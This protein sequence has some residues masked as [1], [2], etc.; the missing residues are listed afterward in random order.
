MVTYLLSTTQGAG[1]PGGPKP[2][3]SQPT[4]YLPTRKRYAHIRYCRD[5]VTSYP[6]VPPIGKAR[7]DVIRGGPGIPVWGPAALDVG[8]KTP[9]TAGQCLASNEVLAPRPLPAVGSS[10][11]AA[12]ARGEAGRGGRRAAGG[13]RGAGSGRGAGEERGAGGERAA[14]SGRESTTGEILA[15]TRLTTGLSP[16]SWRLEVHGRS[17]A[18][19][20]RLRDSPARSPAATASSR[21]WVTARPPGRIRETALGPRQDSAGL[22]RTAAGTAGLRGC[23]AAGSR[24]RTWGPP[25]L[26]E[27]GAPRPAVGDAFVFPPLRPTSEAR[28]LR[29]R[30]A[31]VPSQRAAR[32]PANPGASPGAAGRGGAPWRPRRGQ[33]PGS[34]LSLWILAL[35]PSVNRS[36][37]MVPQNL[38]PWGPGRADWLELE[39]VGTRK[40][41]LG[42]VLKAYGGGL[43]ARYLV[44]ELRAR[45]CSRIS[46][47]ARRHSCCCEMFKNLFNGHL[48]PPLLLYYR[49]SLL[50]TISEGAARAPARRCPARLGG[51]SALMGVRTPGVPPR[52]PSS[53]RCQGGPRVSVESGSVLGAQS[54]GGTLCP[55]RAPQDGSGRA[56][57]A[58]P[59]WEVRGARCGSAVGAGTGSA[60]RE[61]SAL[62]APARCGGV[63][64]RQGSSA[65]PRGSRPAQQ[66]RG[67]LRGGSSEA[68]GGGG[69]RG[70]WGRPR[71]LQAG[72]GPRGRPPEPGPAFP[73]S[74]PR[75]P[76]VPEARCE[77]RRGPWHRVRPGRGC[78]PW[79]PDRASFAA[80]PPGPEPA[81]NGC[82]GRPGLRAQAPLDAAEARVHPRPRRCPALLKTPLNLSGCEWPAGRGGGAGADRAPGGGFSAPRSHPLLRGARGLSRRRGFWGPRPRRSRH[83]PGTA[84]GAA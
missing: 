30:L 54:P 46:E 77:G 61:P 33:A 57:A 35:T 74:E 31:A 20:S 44:T 49:K 14:E 21:A 28:G 62:E 19:P 34:L 16:S 45:G 29:G 38:D 70:I 84:L 4:P 32:V 41:D 76:R 59:G 63:P 10:R 6:K 78:R 82:S 12:P 23:G 81:A 43:T 7:N 5:C 22:G 56:P 67:A 15:A 69:P 71:G 58:P 60:P 50:Q 26:R 27:S 25:W 11:S 55:D 53:R 68:A 72:G 18:A 51:S 64:G 2:F 79:S 52:T 47:A 17:D 1:G 40:E 36:L 83:R 13:G 73:L 48:S 37:R 3:E 39:R 24:G 75:L 66:P 80:S 65:R 8:L 9:A 42:E